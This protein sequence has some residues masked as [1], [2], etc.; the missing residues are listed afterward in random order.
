MAYVTGSEI[1][2][3]LPA[4]GAGVTLAEAQA[5]VDE[6]IGRINEAAGLTPPRRL[7]RHRYHPPDRP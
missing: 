7:P 6:W 2:A 3:M 1:R 5:F 4:D